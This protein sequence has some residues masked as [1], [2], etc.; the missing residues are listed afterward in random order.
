MNPKSK[1]TNPESV[2]FFVSVV[3]HEQADIDGRQRGEDQGLDETDKQPEREN[4]HLDRQP[5]GPGEAFAGGGAAARTPRKGPVRAP[6]GSTTGTVRSSAS[7][8]SR[9]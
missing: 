1:I 4:R 2:M 7:S 6:P 8:R 3:L 9:P 5:L